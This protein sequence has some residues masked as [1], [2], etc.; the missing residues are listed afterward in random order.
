M[1]LKNSST[2]EVPSVAHLN[3]CTGGI[4]AR[5]I[6]CKT[7]LTLLIIFWQKRFFYLKKRMKF[8]PAP[9]MMTL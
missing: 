5:W 7:S 9:G 6:T 2:L 4:P 8:A 1:F 3:V